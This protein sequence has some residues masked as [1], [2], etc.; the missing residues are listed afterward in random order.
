M[1]LTFL[2]APGFVR[3]WDRLGL[4]DGDLRALEAQIE[5]APDSPPVMPGTGGLRK[6]RFAAPSRHTGKRGAMRVG[7]GYL[8]MKSAILMVVIFAKNE[9]SDLSPEQKSG[10][11]KWLTLMERDFK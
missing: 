9:A 11:R 8:R 10:I 2:Y 7:F 6:L 4:T 3:E 1:K 5:K